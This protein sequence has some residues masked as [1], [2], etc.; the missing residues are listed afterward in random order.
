M[1]ESNFNSLRNRK[2]VKYLF[3]RVNVNDIFYNCLN[4]SRLKFHVCMILDAYLVNSLCVNNFFQV[5]L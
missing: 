2:T 4:F 1:K 5:N 3:K